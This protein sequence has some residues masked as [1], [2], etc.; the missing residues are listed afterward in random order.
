MTKKKQSGIAYFFTSLFMKI[1][2]AFQKLP[3]MGEID[4]QSSVPPARIQSKKFG[5]S[6]GFPM[7]VEIKVNKE[8]SIPDNAGKLVKAQLFD[9]KEYRDK[10]LIFNVCFSCGKGG[11]LKKGT[12]TDPMSHWFNVFFGYYEI[13]VPV[14]TWKRPFGYQKKSNTHVPYFPDI[15]R[16]GLADWNYFSNYMYGI[17]ASAASKSSN[18]RDPR[19]KTRYIKRETLGNKYW[20]MV[21]V[22]NFQVT[23]AY[24]APGKSH[25]LQERSLWTRLWRMSF[26]RPHPRKTFNENFIPCRMKA[27]F[28]LSFL[29]DF[30]NDCNE[31]AYKT[32]MFGGTVNHDC[33][34]D[35]KQYAR[36]SGVP[37]H[38][39]DIKAYND[40]FLDEQMKAVRNVIE[41]NFSHLGFDHS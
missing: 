27:R 35:L 7:A 15:I 5:K 24:T 6:S 20:D 26:G 16:I 23:S 13:D 40:E 21:E 4:G 9:E 29:E 18:P 28:Y 34:I 1:K 36:K 38:E 31:M 17:P 30:D 39:F 25:V 19:I 32:F 12:Y 3:I 33:A 8:D 37:F 22:D 14:R 2:I 41:D 10:N 11:L